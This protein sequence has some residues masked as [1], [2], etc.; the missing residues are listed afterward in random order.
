ML[1]LLLVN[2][3]NVTERL[4]A[5]RLR[6]V[7]VRDGRVFATLRAPARELLPHSAG[8]AEFA[9]RGRIRGDVVARILVRPPVHGPKR[10]FHLRL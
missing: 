8:I 10:A 9:Y 1:E 3:G 7:L 5:D 4:G 2:R 6:L